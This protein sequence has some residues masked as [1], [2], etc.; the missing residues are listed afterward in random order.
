MLS[1]VA[2]AKEEKGDNPPPIGASVLG[3]WA[4]VFLALAAG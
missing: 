4:A 1:L 3:E 2:F